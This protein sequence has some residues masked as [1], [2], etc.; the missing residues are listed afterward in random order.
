[1]TNEELYKIFEEGQRKLKSRRSEG[2]TIK[3]R[4]E[5]THSEDLDYIIEEAIRMGWKN[6]EVQVKR[7]QHDG[8][9]VFY[10]E[11]YEEGCTC[12][13]LL[14]YDDYVIGDKLRYEVKD[15]N[16]LGGR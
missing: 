12:P 5:Y 11:P 4:W 1:M 9:H 13:G 2:D 15:E 6:N 16:I 8:K 10:I 7:Y 3:V 14:K